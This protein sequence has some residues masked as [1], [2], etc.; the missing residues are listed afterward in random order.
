LN[1][2]DELLNGPR[3]TVYYKVPI[4]PTEKEEQGVG[5]SKEE[6]EEMQRSEPYQKKIK[7][8]HL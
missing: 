2:T 3:A 1:I 6:I 7:T 8:C 4:S 5:F